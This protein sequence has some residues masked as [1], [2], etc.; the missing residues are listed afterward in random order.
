[1]VGGRHI[2]LFLRKISPVMIAPNLLLMLA[3]VLFLT[4]TPVSARRLYGDDVGAGGAPL[5]L[6]LPC[7]RGERARDGRDGCGSV[8]RFVC[9]SLAAF[10][11]AVGV[12]FQLMRGPLTEWLYDPV[13]LR[14]RHNTQQTHR[15]SRQRLR[16]VEVSPM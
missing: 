3:V 5:W 15:G 7:R 11:T 6:P 1:V 2:K 10:T 4:A 8:A 12:L 16:S 13:A 9:W 14:E